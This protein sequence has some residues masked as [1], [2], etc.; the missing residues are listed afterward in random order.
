MSMVTFSSCKEENSTQP[1]PTIED[2]INAAKPITWVSTYT[3]NNLT[4]QYYSNGG[5]LK[6]VYTEKGYLVVVDLN[7]HYFNLSLASEITIDR[8]NIYLYY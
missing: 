5:N 1:I 8:H 3:N 7:I 6:D 4:G 2:R